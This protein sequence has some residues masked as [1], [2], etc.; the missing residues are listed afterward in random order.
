MEIKSHIEIWDK[1]T[2]IQYYILLNNEMLGKCYIQ[3]M[4]NVVQ[5]CG[6]YVLPKYRK[7]GLGKIIINH[8]LDEHSNIYIKVNK[9]YINLINWYK[10]LG[11]KH[12]SDSEDPYIWMLHKNKTKKYVKTRMGRTS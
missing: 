9:S 12:H 6:L 8:I 11:F 1:H 7:N 5:L 2:S 3:I 10:Q 4:D